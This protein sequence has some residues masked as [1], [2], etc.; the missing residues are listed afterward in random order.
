MINVTLFGINMLL[1]AIVWKYVFKP[2]VL[3]HFRDR[4]FDLREEVRSF[5]ICNNLSLKEKT[6]KNL[7]NIINRHL[8]FMEQL[9]LMEIIYFGYKIKRTGLRPYIKRTIDKEFQTENNHLRE[10]IND[11]RRRSIIVLTHYMILS[12]P[13]LL[14]LFTLI[15]ILEIPKILLRF[16]FR[17]SS[18]KTSWVG[19]SIS[20]T[21]DI[22]KKHVVTEEGL[23]EISFE[24]AV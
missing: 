23:E 19:G 8:R 20:E 5:Y 21:S 17:R 22:V 18:S 13:I 7:R 16:L 14:A 15:V 9:S 2:S 4:L 24:C 6:Y 1:V 12:S 11:V 3:D 10:F